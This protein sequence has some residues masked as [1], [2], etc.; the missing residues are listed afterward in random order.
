MSRSLTDTHYKSDFTGG[1]RAPCGVVIDGILRERS[2]TELDRI[3]CRS[4][5]KAAVKDVRKR[6]KKLVVVR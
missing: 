6:L 4:C 5:R 3:T 1:Y 2:S